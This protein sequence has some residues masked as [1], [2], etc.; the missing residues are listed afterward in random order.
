MSKQTTATAKGRRHVDRAPILRARA[1][2]QGRDYT[3]PEDVS[4]LLK[5]VS[6]AGGDPM[7]IIVELLAV[8]GRVG[9]ISAE[10][11]GLCAY[12]AW[13]HLRKAKRK[14]AP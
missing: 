3:T 2:R 11:A 10:D 9:G 14:V 7:P 4:D 5:E 8:L 1:E 13:E 6:K 12:N